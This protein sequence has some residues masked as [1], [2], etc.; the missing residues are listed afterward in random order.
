MQTVDYI[1]FL[2]EKEV[3][4]NA[5]QTAHS[6]RYPIVSIY[7]Y[8]LQKEYEDLVH[9]YHYINS[10]SNLEVAMNVMKQWPHSTFVAIDEIIT[11]DDT[12]FYKHNGGTAR[13]TFEIFR[14]GA[15][16][17]PRLCISEQWFPASLIN[18]EVIKMAIEKMEPWKDSELQ[19]YDPVFE[20]LSTCPS[21]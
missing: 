3:F 10:Y 19:I 20:F 12:R 6:R 8:S 5:K 16:I 4:K 1:T 17:R 14:S 18:G 2:S 21:T 15:Y 7:V 11:V 13:N 9:K